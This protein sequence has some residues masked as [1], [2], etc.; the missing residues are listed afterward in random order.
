MRTFRQGFFRYILYN[1]KNLS[2]HLK[3]STKDNNNEKMNSSGDAVENSIYEEEQQEERFM[4]EE[5]EDEEQQQQQQNDMV[6]YEDDNDDVVDMLSVNEVYGKVTVVKLLALINK[7]LKQKSVARSELIFIPTT[8]NPT[9]FIQR[10]D[11]MKTRSKLL[12]IQKHSSVNKS[13]PIIREEKARYSYFHAKTPT[14]YVTKG[15]NGR[16]YPVPL[17]GKLG[18]GPQPHHLQT[19]PGLLRDLLLWDMPQRSPAFFELDMCAA[20]PSILLAVLAGCLG[21]RSTDDPKVK[22]SFPAIHRVVFEKQKVRRDIMSYYTWEAKETTRTSLLKDMIDRAEYRKTPHINPTLKASTIQ[23]LEMVATTSPLT[24]KIAKAIITSM[25][26]G[27]RSYVEKYG[28]KPVDP[29][30]PTHHPFLQNI[31]RDLNNAVTT[32]Q[33]HLTIF[34]TNFLGPALEKAKTYS[35]KQR[36]KR[37]APKFSALALFLQDTE[38]RVMESTLS[39]IDQNM[40]DEDDKANNVAPQIQALCHDGIYISARSLNR[41]DDESLDSLSLHIEEDVDFR[42]MNGDRVGL[43]G[44][45]FECKEIDQGRVCETNE[46]LESIRDNGIISNHNNN[47]NDVHSTQ[48]SSSMV[49]TSEPDSSTSMALDSLGLSTSTLLIPD[50][51]IIRPSSSSSNSPPKNSNENF[52][53]A[54]LRVRLGLE[55]ENSGFSVGALQKLFAKEWDYTTKEELDIDLAHAVQSALFFYEVEKMTEPVKHVIALALQPIFDVFVRIHPKEFYVLSYEFVKTPGNDTPLRFLKDYQIWT[56]AEILKS[57]ELSP[58]VVRAAKGPPVFLFD[59][60]IKTG[61][62]RKASIQKTRVYHKLGSTFDPKDTGKLNLKLISWNERRYLQEGFNNVA[63]NGTVYDLRLAFLFLYHLH[64]LI[65]GHHPKGLEEILDFCII[66][67]NDNDGDSNVKLDIDENDL[68]PG[69]PTSPEELLNMYDWCDDALWYWYILAKK[70]QFGGFY[71]LYITVF[72]SPARGN[73]KSLVTEE[74]PKLLYNGP[75]DLGSN[76]TGE[77]VITTTLKKLLAKHSNWQRTAEI[78]TI[79]EFDDRDSKKNRAANQLLKHSA[80]SPTHMIRELYKQAQ[81]VK[82][83]TLLLAN[84]NERIPTYIEHSG[85]RRIYMIYCLRKTPEAGDLHDRVIYSIYNYCG[86][87]SSCEEHDADIPGNERAVIS[88][89]AALRNTQ[90]TRK[91]HKELQ[92][93]PSWSADR[94]H[95]MAHNSNVFSQFEEWLTTNIVPICIFERL[96]EFDSVDHWDMYDENNVDIYVDSITLT[97]LFKI[98]MK[99]GQLSD[100]ELDIFHNTKKNVNNKI[101]NPM[102]SPAWAEPINTGEIKVFNFVLESE[103][104]SSYY[105]FTSTRRNDLGSARSV[106]EPALNRSPRTM[107]KLRNRCAGKT[108]PTKKRPRSDEGDVDDDD[109]HRDKMAR[110][111]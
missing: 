40:C 48:R 51:T 1:V 104:N 7:V 88:L 23:Q 53:A 22:K 43:P 17:N 63:E 28:L 24:M 49:T 8:D 5:E 29:H 54:S 39:F 35:D 34:R 33:N 2:Y 46:A 58:Y 31:H 12:H 89:Y 13:G 100:G 45:K 73:G 21:S 83:Q 61:R 77:K 103:N 86:I 11:L 91:K 99:H 50:T 36:K 6:D 47:N 106:A 14:I 26:F 65:S 98:Y 76:S 97:S 18:G 107:Y 79:C 71:T 25:F 20:H 70:M 72:S 68:P 82:N 60:M 80:T 105:Q 38:R 59:L 96:H 75:G 3:T 15:G 30:A 41:F 32:L 66:D 4:E 84:T 44:I 9:R 102:R 27:N 57:C 108:R 101:D 42:L 109:M 64:V 111:E 52:L 69:F 94:V 10:I 78:A 92:M 110:F 16:V 81:S 87:G 93:I 55:G 95:E 62:I 37:A 74:I 85:V 90:I 19:M 67:D 56:P